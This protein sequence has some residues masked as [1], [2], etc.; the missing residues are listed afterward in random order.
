[1]VKISFKFRMVGKTESQTETWLI[2][3]AKNDHYNRKFG[4]I[5]GYDS[6]SLRIEFVKQ[7]ETNKDSANPKSASSESIKPELIC[8][9]RADH[10]PR[11]SLRA[12]WSL[13]SLFWLGSTKWF[14][15]EKTK[16]TSPLQQPQQVCSIARSRDGG[17]H[18]ERH[19][20]PPS[21]RTGH[22]HHRFCPRQRDGEKERERE[23]KGL[24][25]IERAYCLMANEGHE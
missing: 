14:S 2:T 22:Q 21:G 1:M 19:G 11:V 15:A 13:A 8:E 10:D 18:Q 4:S 23:R 12:T 6:P 7:K 9:K 16:L 17:Q 25:D 20:H 5:W 3:L 24:I